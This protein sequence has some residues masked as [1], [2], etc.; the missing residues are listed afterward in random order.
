MDYIKQGLRSVDDIIPLTFHTANHK[1][2]QRL[3]KGEIMKKRLIA[4]LLA[5]GV[6][7]ATLGMARELKKI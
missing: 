4:S 6:V 2:L 5:A 1:C 7:G 3:F